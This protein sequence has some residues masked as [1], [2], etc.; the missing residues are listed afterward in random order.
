MD[1]NISKLIHEVKLKVVTPLFLGN[2]RVEE[3]KDERITN[4]PSELRPPSVKGVL[5]FWYRAASPDNLKTEA[6]CFGSIKGQSSFLLQVK[7]SPQL[8]LNKA[9]EEWKTELG[10]LGYGPILGVKLNNGE[11]KRRL[12]SRQYIEPG[13]DLIFRLVFHP[14]TTQETKNAVLRSFCLLSLFGGLGS[15]SRRGFG[16]VIYEKLNFSNIKELSQCIRNEL[17]QN[18]SLFDETNL[19]YTA[20]GVQTRVLLL[21]GKSSWEETLQNIGGLLLKYRSFRTK[22]PES[23]LPKR[24]HDL[25]FNF[26]HNQG[27][28]EAPA[29]SVYGLPHN[30]FFSS[31]N[32]N[33]I[34]EGSN[35]QFVRRASPLFFHIHQL[36]TGQYITVVS[37][38]PAQ[39]LPKGEFL[40]VKEKKAFK[41]NL[42]SPLTVPDWT[43][44]SDFLKFIKDNHDAME[45]KWNHE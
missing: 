29:R 42:S 9:G 8:H 1:E 18:P 23:D 34:V 17:E 41:E 38:F 45:V 37:F 5:R 39:F 43:A 28:S 11:K 22:P 36:R 4:I 25:V 27:I 30:Y 10:Y 44:I 12:L 3:I 16:S 6:E 31:C 19:T 13:E 32:L 35:D 33:A 24:D 26:L 40:K 14:G 7:N 20:I 2:A 21:E 15:R